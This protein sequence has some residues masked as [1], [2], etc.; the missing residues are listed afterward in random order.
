ME[1]KAV[2]LILDGHQDHESSPKCLRGDVE[3]EEKEIE[4]DD[5]C[6]ICQ[7]LLYKPVIT[8]CKHTLCESCMAHWADVS[9]TS[10]MTIVGLEDEAAI[11]LPNEI[12]TRC[13]M[14][15][16]S[17]AA[18]IDGS[19]ASKLSSQYP[20]TYQVREA[21]ERN[22]ENNEAVETETRSNLQSESP[23]KL[24]FWPRR[25]AH[26]LDR[27]GL[28]VFE[29]DNPIQKSLKDTASLKLNWEHLKRRVTENELNEASSAKTQGFKLGLTAYNRYA[30]E[31]FAALGRDT[32][33][34]RT[35]RN[36]LP[37]LHDH[38]F[39]EKQA[40]RYLVNCPSHP[41]YYTGNV[42]YECLK[43]WRLEKMSY[44]TEA[45]SP[46]SITTAARYRRQE[47]HG[48]SLRI[49]VRIVNFMLTLYGRQS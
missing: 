46:R 37:D 32:K 39:G 24:S 35:D 47:I 10:Q 23:T 43:P 14:C 1:H 44:A 15:R 30:Q 7:N 21:E 26:Y 6:P 11:L 34:L 5:L 33:A 16:S 9:I 3:T 28:G 45:I 36:A 20:R 48:V 40:P 31:A 13:P 17:T 41:D 18:S 2:T 22:V 4:E 49:K 38:E 25:Y 19:R 27:S 8:R 42:Q 29:F 12:E